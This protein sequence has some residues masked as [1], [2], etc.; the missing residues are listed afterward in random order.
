MNII[1]RMYLKVMLWR[2]E[3]QIED[4]YFDRDLSRRIDAV[5]FL[6]ESRRGI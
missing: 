3:K 6:L 2:L 4:C 1:D 5:R